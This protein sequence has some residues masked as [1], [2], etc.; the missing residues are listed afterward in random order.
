MMNETEITFPM[1]DVEYPKEE[2]IVRE[3]TIILDSVFVERKS[4]IERWKDT[5]LGPGLKVIFYQCGNSWLIGIMVYLLVIGSCIGLQNVAKYREFLPLMASPILY[6]T[7]SVIS[8]WS[9]EQNEVIELKQ[10]MKYSFSY[11]ISLRMFWV[12]VISVLMNL[13]L[14]SVFLKVE[15]WSVGAISVT[16]MFLFSVISLYCYQCFGNYYHIFALAGIWLILCNIFAQTGVW[17]HQFL[18]NTIPLVVHVL[19][20][21][22]SFVGY[23]MFIRK[24]ELRNAYAY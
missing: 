5:Y 18:F 21:V 2:T 20:A 8:Y 22:A 24:V 9:E 10:T 4:I 11:L 23:L 15:I 14:F 16:S 7:F 17:M 3:K 6:L 13:A 19:V 1:L 12:S